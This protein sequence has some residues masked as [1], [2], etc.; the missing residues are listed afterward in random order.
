MNKT[1]PF[2]V[3]IL[4]VGWCLVANAEPISSPTTLMFLRPYAGDNMVYVRVTE[5]D[6]CETL[7]FGIDVSKP[8]GKEMYAAA[9]SALLAGAPVQVEISDATGC[10]G[11][12][13]LLQSIYIHQP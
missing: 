10:T 11:W 3:L 12:G 9:L 7:V 8:T 5:S 2:A 13:T 4:V 1:L 6:V